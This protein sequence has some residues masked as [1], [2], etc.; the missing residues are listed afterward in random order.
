MG[1]LRISEELYRER[2]DR[3]KRLIDLKAP[4]SIIHYSLMLTLESFERLTFREWWFQ[5]VF[6][7]KSPHWLMWISSRYYREA[8][9]EDLDGVE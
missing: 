3:M 9:R 4:D 8:C 5:R 7:K 2:L 1:R 6:W